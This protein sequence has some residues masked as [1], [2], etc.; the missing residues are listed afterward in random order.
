MLTGCPACGQQVS[1]EAAGCPKCG[2]PNRQ[3]GAAGLRC[4]ACAAPA[5][6]KCHSCGALSCVQHLQSTYVSHGD[7]GA[8]E[9]RCTSCYSSAEARNEIG[10]VFLAIAFAVGLVIIGCLA[11]R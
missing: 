6:T 11:S 10:R 3:A 7:G 1:T 4:Y 9:L 8:Y 2:H 5:T